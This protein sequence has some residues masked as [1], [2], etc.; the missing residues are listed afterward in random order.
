MAY[1]RVM[2]ARRLVG[3][4]ALACIAG[5]GII[6]SFDSAIG[7]ATAL[8]VSYPA[9]LTYE[10]SPVPDRITMTLAGDP[11]TT[12]AVSWR[13]DTS[14]ATPQA[15]IAEVTGGT[16]FKATA[17]TVAASS[18]TPVQ[19]DFATPAIF[20]TVEFTGLEP[21]TRYL[22]RVG[23]GLNWSEWIEF[24]TA[25]TENEPF[26]LIYLGDAQN[27]IKEHWSRVIRRAY[28][29]RPEAELIIH[30][31]DLVNTSTSDKEWAERYVAGGWIDGMV[32]NVAT[33]GNH[34][35]S[36]PVLSPYWR[37][38][39]AY[40]L[41]GPQ[42]EGTIYEAMKESVYYVDYQGVRIISL[43]SNS[44]AA[45]GATADW[46]RI[47]AE[48][49]EEVL[50]NNPNEWTIVTFHHPVFA[51]SP[52][53][54][55]R[56]LRNAWRPIFEKYGVDLVLQGHD[57][58]YARGNVVDGVSGVSGGVVYVVS[59]SG[60]KMYDLSD[61]NWTQNGAQQRK[62]LKNMQLYQLIDVAAGVLRYEARTADG[63]PYDL[64]EILK[65]ADGNK[66]I[67]EK[68]DESAPARSH[69]HG[70]G[71]HSH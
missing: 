64:F 67:V 26:S 23:D 44:G 28:S 59:V 21:S 5:V 71:T 10:S 20:H 30:A 32:T 13:T 60:P 52:S 70:S 49:L 41:N 54:D 57:H 1:T 7:Q 29:D 63:K 17:T 8:P 19:A 6:S 42:G 22:Y 48:W 27:D 37:P 50:Q 56:D 3:A 53:R 14:V 35:Y 51:N 25:S 33:P 12:R 58:S 46:W 31:G 39:F 38:Q 62:A 47:Q 40:P 18:S 24:D 34:E 11:T 65:D 69:G 15:Q 43:N 2:R 36:G 9:Q 4:S 66:T 55:N 45:A 16:Q 61:Q 68:H